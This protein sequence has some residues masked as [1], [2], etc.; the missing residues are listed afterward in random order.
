MIKNEIIMRL[1][2]GSS[3]EISESTGIL[4]EGCNKTEECNNK[5]KNEFIEPICRGD[6]EGRFSLFP[7]EHADLWS[8]YKQHVASFWTADEIDLSNDVT[9]WNNN[10]T[11]NERHFIS[12]VLAFFAGA[13]GIVVENL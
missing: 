6:D 5:E 9:D 11:P 13:D 4:D 7:I 1:R 2:G 3:T 10:L 8:M 12:M